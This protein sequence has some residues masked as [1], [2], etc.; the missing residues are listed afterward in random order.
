[1]D[2]AAREVAKQPLAGLSG[3]EGY[4]P[5]GLPDLRQAIARHL[6]NRGLP[7]REDEL[8]VTSGAQ[9]GISLLASLL[10]ARGE[11]VV[12]EDPT[13]IGAIDV[14]SAMGARLLATAG[15]ADTLDVDRLHALLATRPRLCYLVPDFHNPTG[16]VLPEHARREIARFCEELQVPVVEDCSLSDLGLT[17]DPPPPIASYRPNAPVLTLGSFSKLFWTGLRVGY[18]RGPEGLITRL[19]RFKALSDLGSAFF[20][21]AMTIRLLSEWRAARQQRQQELKTKLSLLEALLAAQLPTIQFKRPEGGMLLWARWGEGDAGDLAHIAAQHGVTVVPG[22]GNSPDR[23]FSDF[24][25]LPFVA[26]PATMAEGIHRL[27][28]AAKAYQPQQ[29][30]TR[31]TF[32]VIV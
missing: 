14:F 10:V 31:A 25:R 28:I 1:V 16:A 6:T 13:Y 23:H 29:K 2:E 3:N 19:G 24:L 20:P 12:T 8:M 27:A 32:D 15:Y 26:D 9:Q 21:Q 30:E 5:M 7:T 22:S 11:T 17:G 18:L 4:F